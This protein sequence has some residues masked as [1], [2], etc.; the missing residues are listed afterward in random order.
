MYVQV[1]EMTRDNWA[2]CGK[3]VKTVNF[4]ENQIQLIIRYMTKSSH[5]FYVM[6]F[7]TSINSPPSYQKHL[8][9]C[10]WENPRD[11]KFINMGSSTLYLRLPVL[12]LYSF[13]GNV[14]RLASKNSDRLCVR[15]L[16]RI[17]CKPVQMKRMK[18]TKSNESKYKLESILLTLLPFSQRI[19]AT[20]IQIKFL[21]YSMRCFNIL[22]NYQIERNFMKLW[23]TENEL[24][25]KMSDIYFGRVCDN[26]II[27]LEITH[28]R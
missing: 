23:V 16:L 24:Q 13:A 22:L 7:Y 19:K 17:W 1:S 14:R 15:L 18:N 8:G 2:T 9:D 10:T 20:T 4:S 3:I 28:L 5:W 26:M 6:L 11:L 21:K 12:L 25:V 27:Q